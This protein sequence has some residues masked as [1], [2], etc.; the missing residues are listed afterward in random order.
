MHVG[1][2]NLFITERDVA[3]MHKIAGNNVFR[4]KG[5]KS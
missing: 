5:K 4:S 3:F 2:S 1:N